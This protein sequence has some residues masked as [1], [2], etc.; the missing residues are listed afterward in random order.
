[1]YHSKV[2]ILCWAVIYFFG[3]AAALIRR[4]WDGMRSVLIGAAIVTAGITASFILNNA[5]GALVLSAALMV[6]TYFTLVGFIKI[7]NRSMS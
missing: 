6:A 2:M 3:L 1:M 7:F 5:L 4:R